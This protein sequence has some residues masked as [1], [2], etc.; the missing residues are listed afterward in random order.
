M[1]KYNKKSKENIFI[2]PEKWAVKVT[3]ENINIIN[4]Y[5]NSCNIS[6]L[7]DLETYQFA[8]FLGYGIYRKS[9]DKGYVEITFEEFEKYVLHR[10]ILNDEDL[11]YLI[12]LF[13]KLNIN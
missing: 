1:S 9:L 13:K 8:E 2:L 11:S 12:K 6:G 7:F 5:R 4:D 3:K 10:E